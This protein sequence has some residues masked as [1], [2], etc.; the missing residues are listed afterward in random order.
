[1]W[2]GT[3][4]KRRSAPVARPQVEFLEDRCLLSPGQLDTTF[5][6][7]GSVTS[8]L[9]SSSFAYATA[10]Q[11]DG[12]ILAAGQAT[13]G[14]GYQ[15]GLARYTTSGSLDTSF[16]SSGTVTTKI[17]SGGFAWATAV[18]PTDGKIVLG[19][20][21]SFSK[22]GNDFALAR[23]T[24]SGSLD[25][26]FGNRGTTST[27]LGIGDDE[28][29]ALAIQSDGKIIAAGTSQQSGQYQWGLARYTT[30]GSLD[31]SFGSGG[32]VVST[33]G[34]GSNVQAE[35]DGIAL[36]SDG[37]IVVTGYVSLA[38]LDGRQFAVARYNANGTLDTSF[39]TSGTG[40]VYLT[41]LTTLHEDTGH[42]IVIQSDGKI[43]AAGTLSATNSYEE[44]AL[45]RFNS[46][47]TL[48]STFGS[49][50]EVTQQI[51]TGANVNDIAFGVALQSDGKLI[52]AG[53]HNV[54]SVGNPESFA[55]GRFNSD[56]SLDTTFNGTGLVTTTIGTTSDA[57]GVL[58]QP[59]DGKI[60]VTGGATVSG[61]SNFAVA[62]YLGGSTSP[63]AAAAFVA[64]QT[65]AQ[66]SPPTAMPNAATELLLLPTPSAS[67]PALITTLLLP[68]VSAPVQ[69]SSLPAVHNETPV[70]LPVAAP[71]VSA[72][73]VD[74]LFSDPLMTSDAAV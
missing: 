74:W 27:A 2:F 35:I 34:P 44:W 36:Q 33:F 16:G 71:V 26:S 29:E 40:V 43:V 6:S 17:G 18:Q 7:G 1:M 49:G 65:A 15:F 50:G 3:P 70:P 30:S 41:P 25:K 4:H 5:G 68:I 21:G 38:G 61:V 42:G 22:T 57:R 67:P 58:I 46:D 8:L 13:V 32:T 60:V 28:I 23:Y 59:T 10:L 66:S 54:N 52:I 47:G 72:A 69:D 53:T 63:I 45:A 12:K 39:G 73:A 64:E 20:F 48:D 62:R 55:L 11:S 51:V 37:K 56:G 31:T 19:G 24:T 14:S 9:G